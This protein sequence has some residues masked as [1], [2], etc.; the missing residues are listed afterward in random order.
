L[1]DGGAG[2]RFNF[3]GSALFRPIDWDEWFANFDAHGL[4]FVYDNETAGGPVS[5]RYRLVKAADWE[6][7]IR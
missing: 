4:S 5:N 1:N 3:P 6:D 2:V 7:T